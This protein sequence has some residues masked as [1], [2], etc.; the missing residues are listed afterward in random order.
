MPPVQARQ[1][2]QGEVIA[3]VGKLEPARR[4]EIQRLVE[5]E[6]VVLEKVAHHKLVDALFEFHVQVLKFVSGGKAGHIEAVRQHQVRSPT[7]EYPRTRGRSRH[8]R[9]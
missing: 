2:L 1:G 6:G 4:E 5:I 8:L 9:W 3:F 7:Q